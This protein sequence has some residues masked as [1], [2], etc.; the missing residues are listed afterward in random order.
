M[1]SPVL[2]DRPACPQ[3]GQPIGAYEP[4]WRFA[5]DLG[6]ERTS[7]L[8]ARDRLGPMDALWHVACAEADGVDGG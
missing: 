7:W 1:R 8:Q 3:C 2:P 6:A 5:P 4:V